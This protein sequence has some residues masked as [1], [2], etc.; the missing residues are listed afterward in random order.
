MVLSHPPEPWH[1]HG[2][3]AAGVYLVPVRDLPAPP[4][5]GTRVVSV[6]GRA[7]VTTAFFRYRAPSPLQYGEVMA[8][9]LVRRGWRPRIFIPQIWVDSPASRDG[10]R[11]LWAIPKQLARFEGDPERAMTAAGLSTLTVGRSLPALPRLPISFRVV[12]QRASRGVVTPVSGRVDASLARARWRHTGDLAWLAGRR[13]VLSIVVRR[14]RLTFG[15][16]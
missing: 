12:Q 7:V 2:S 3:A 14:F 6:L 4:P 16:R 10:G 11:E 15:R 5:P 1:L 13:A 9:V 8:T